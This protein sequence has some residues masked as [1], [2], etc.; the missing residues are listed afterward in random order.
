M[1]GKRS[2]CSFWSKSLIS[3]QEPLFVG[4]WHLTDR[5]GWLKKE[6]KT[7]RGG[8]GHSGKC[9]N[10]IWPKRKGEKRGRCAEEDYWIWQLII[11]RTLSEIYMAETRDGPIWSF[12]L[13]LRIQAL[14]WQHH[15][16]QTNIQT[17]YYYYHHHHRT[18]NMESKTNGQQM[19]LSRIDSSS[20]N[21]VME[22][23]ATLMGVVLTTII[24]FLLLIKLFCSNNNTTKMIVDVSYCLDVPNRKK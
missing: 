1:Y 4:A 24:I 17:N 16:Q 10:E 19:L 22:A 7:A 23:G 18:S 9:G 3:I 2:P 15:Q 14:G 13:W 5:L 6:R 11:H 20:P 12:H 8:G 21:W